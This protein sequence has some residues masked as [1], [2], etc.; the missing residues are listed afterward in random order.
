[1][2]VEILK[3]RWTGKVREVTIG[4]KK[5][6]GGTRASVVTLGGATG[7]PFLHFEG[8]MPNPP[9]LALEVFDM[10]PEEWPATLVEPYKDVLGNPVEWAQKC[11]EEYG[12]DLVLIRLVSAD[13]DLKNSSPDDAV[14][15]VTAVR[16]AVGVPLI[17][18]GCGD[19]DKDN[20]VMPAVGEA[21]A[22]ENCL[23]GIA[24]QENYKSLVATCMVNK[25]NII[26]QSPLDINI[27]KQLNILITEMGL[28]AEN[29][30]I[31]P[32]SGALGYGIEY[33]YSIMERVRLG[34]L[35]GDKMLA[36]PVVIFA[37]QEAWRAKEAKETED[38]FP[39][40]GPETMRGPLWEMMTASTLLQAGADLIVLRHPL[41]LEKLREHIAGLMADAG[42]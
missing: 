40:W 24:K 38:A 20:Q 1:M 9:G 33:C 5:D 12:A 31:D 36:M 30:V 25:H 32:M 37:G 27:C 29:I 15:T 41:A 14:K 34:S 23:L 21:L 17:V 2:A 7:L 35:Q 11:V 18:V 4:A 10:V 26:A 3:E 28:P 22:G 39:E 19:P 13:P 42:Q 8:T 6:A 16:D